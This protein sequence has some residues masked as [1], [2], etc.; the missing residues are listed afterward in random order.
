MSKGLKS[1][2]ILVPNDSLTTF[3]EKEFSNGMM[4]KHK[5]KSVEEFG[6]P[7]TK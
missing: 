7:G 1:L 3:M 4:D 2:E 6:D 5:D